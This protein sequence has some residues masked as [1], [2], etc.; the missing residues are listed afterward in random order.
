MKK[1]LMLLVLLLF[2]CSIQSYGFIVQT[3]RVVRD[4]GDQPSSDYEDY[5]WTFSGYDS[6]KCIADYS[7]GAFSNA[8]FRMLNPKNNNVVI[9][10]ATTNGITVTTTNYVEQVNEVFTQLYN[11]VVSTNYYQ[12]IYTYTNR[13]DVYADY[14]SNAIAIYTTLYTDVIGGTN[15]AVTQIGSSSVI[16]TG[17][18]PTTA[19]SEY[20]TR[21]N[22]YNMNLLVTGIETLRLS[23]A[24]ILYTN[25]VQIGQYGSNEVLN[26][27]FSQAGTNW[28]C[29]LSFVTNGVA[30]FTNLITL[31]TSTLYQ[32]L[33]NV[34]TSGPVYE[35]KFSV[36]NI[37]SARTGTVNFCG[38]TPPI[39]RMKFVIALLGGAYSG[40]R[41]S[42]M[43][44]NMIAVV[45]VILYKTRFATLDLISA[46]TEKRLFKIL[47]VTLLKLT[48]DPQLFCYFIS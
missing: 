19:V 42:P 8:A 41:N 3:N 26:G 7:G 40:F 12:R 28:V 10:L 11:A 6:Q 5:N 31:T 16:L 2:A 17:T 25:I 35:L 30:T 15:L 29:G 36:W 47:N 44:K 1:L 39:I 23:S 48:S 20:G 13:Y 9:D 27:D 37:D 4:L 46:G 22:R 38:Y 33:S 45:N 34:K 24:T 21:T 14:Y 32:A 43:I 18:A